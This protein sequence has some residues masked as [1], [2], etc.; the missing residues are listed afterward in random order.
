MVVDDESHEP[1]NRPMGRGKPPWPTDADPGVLVACLDVRGDQAEPGSPPDHSRE[2]RIEAIQAASRVVAG[3][4]SNATDLTSLKEGG[5]SKAV[6]E[7]AVPIARY[8]ETGK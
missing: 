1:S 8:I 3:I 7:I 4:L 5:V 2:N 6:M